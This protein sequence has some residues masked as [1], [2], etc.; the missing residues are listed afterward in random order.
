VTYEVANQSTVPVLVMKAR[1]S[2]AQ[3]E[4]ICPNLMLRLLYPTDFSE[5]AQRA[6]ETVERLVHAGCN[7]VTLAHVQDRTRIDPH[8][9]GRLPE[10]NLTDAAR[11]EELAERLRSLG[12]DEIDIQVPY[13]SPAEDLLRISR[14]KPY[15]LIVMGS[16]GRSFV[17]ELFLG[18]VSHLLVRRAP[19]PVLLIPSAQ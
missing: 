19:V 4:V 10:F 9:I 15:T 17:K 7:A 8:L 6:F 16:Q 18:S 2:E 1:M 5:T 13:G 14:E 12:A 11:L 3:C